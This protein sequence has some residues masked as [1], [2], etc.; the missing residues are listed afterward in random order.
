MRLGVLA[1]GS[2]GNALVIEHDGRMVF[3]DSGLSGRKHTERLIDAGFE[4]SSPEAIFLSH[5]HSDHIRGAGIVA[6]K[7][8]I[9]VFGSSGT[10]S[11]S[12]KHL[13]KLPYMEIL[14]NG[15][16]ISFGSFSVYAFS[17]AHDAADPSGYIIEW[18]SGKLGI[19]TDLGKSSPLVESSLSGCTAVVL[20]FNHDEDMLWN[21]SY[22]WHLKQRIASTTGHL[23][24][25][26]ASDLLGII[27]HR[28]LKN[29][30]LAHLSQENNYPHL[31]EK[32]SRQVA[33]GKVRIHTGKQDEPLPALDL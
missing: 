31:A 23:S 15:S 32:A 12:R 29:C 25:R 30:V 8:N 20:E 3:F 11:A 2:R 1:S 5:E 17:I 19:A 26:D 21:G 9:P 33:G 13:G 14:D 7:W 28:G 16:C 10:L 4:G 27:Y 24:N 18:D 6:R 22:P